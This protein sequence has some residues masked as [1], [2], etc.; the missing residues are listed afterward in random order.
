MRGGRVFRAVSALVVGIAVP[1]LIYAVNGTVE[2]WAFVLG[3]TIA[4][5][6]YVLPFF[7]AI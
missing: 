2:P 4:I 7:F 6:W 5:A 1:A 3:A